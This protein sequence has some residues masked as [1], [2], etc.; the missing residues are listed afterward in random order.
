MAAAEIITTITTTMAAM[1]V[2][3]TT[4]TTTTEAAGATTIT[5]TTTMEM[6]EVS[7]LLP[8]NLSCNLTTIEFCTLGSSLQNSLNSYLHGDQTQ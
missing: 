1:A 3:T 2:T 8:Q 5:I 7:A 6:A 4:I